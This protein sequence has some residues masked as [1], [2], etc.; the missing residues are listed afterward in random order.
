MWFITQLFLCVA[1]GCAMAAPTASSASTPKPGESHCPSDAFTLQHRVHC[2][3]VDLGQF[4]SQRKNFCGPEMKPMLWEPCFLAGNMPEPQASPEHRAL[5]FFHVG[6]DYQEI[7][8]VSHFWGVGWPCR[9]E[10][11]HGSS[12]VDLCKGRERTTGPPQQKLAFF[13]LVLCVCRFLSL[14]LFC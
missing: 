8:Q 5:L 4:P 2:R 11:A 10:R 13:S 6:L 3:I 7:L 14:V 12:C 9:A 1:L